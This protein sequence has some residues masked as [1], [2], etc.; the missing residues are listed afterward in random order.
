MS[1]QINGEPRISR[2]TEDVVSSEENSREVVG[3][4]L[5]Q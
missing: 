5:I 1:E 2:Q 3:Q 4:D